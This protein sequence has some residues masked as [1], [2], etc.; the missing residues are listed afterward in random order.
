[1]LNKVLN[2]E[3]IVFYSN[4][5]YVIMP[6]L[7]ADSTSHDL[8]MCAMRFYSVMCSHLQ[9]FRGSEEWSICGAP[10]THCAAAGEITNNG[11]PCSN[12]L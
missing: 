6:A 7:P 11:A 2:K 10:D 9:H 5:N 1:M 12:I 3:N 8:M 4:H